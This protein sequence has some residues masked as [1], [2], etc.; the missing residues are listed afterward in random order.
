MQIELQ[1]ERE[2][3]RKQL[4]EKSNDI[5]KLRAHITT[6]EHEIRRLKREVDDLELQIK[7]HVCE[8]ANY[9]SSLIVKRDHPSHQHEC[10]LSAVQCVVYIVNMK[11]EKRIK[12]TKIST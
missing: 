6:H 12:I 11:L 9:S 5:E 8:K 1:Q 10:K 2:D 7:N 4:Y 3:S